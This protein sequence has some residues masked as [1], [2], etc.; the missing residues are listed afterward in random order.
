MNTPSVESNLSLLLMRILFVAN[1]IV[2]G[3]ISITSLFMPAKAQFSVFS[4]TVAY[5]EVIR[6]VGALWFSIFL[7]SLIGIFFPTKMWFVF[8]FQLIYKATWLIAVALP[9]HI[10]G[11]PYPRGMAVCFV[12]WVVIIPFIMPWQ[13]MRLT[14]H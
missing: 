13:M 12:I 14:D 4:G 7:L 1:V 5:S 2:A 11:A 6:L 3:L 8:L 10:Q 9:A